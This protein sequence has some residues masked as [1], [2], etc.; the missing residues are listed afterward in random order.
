MPRPRSDIAP[1]IV[2]AARNRFL[3]DGVDG[4]S[5]RQIADDAG[6]SI[7]MVYYYFPTKDDLFFAVV[8]EKYATI[9]QKI[10]AAIETSTHLQDRILH[11][12][13]L[14]GSL[15]D[16]DLDTVRLVVR[17]ALVSS[18]R[19]SRLLDR[20]ER[21]HLAMVGQVLMEGIATGEIRGDLSLPVVFGV[22]V[23]VGVIPQLVRRFAGARL[24]PGAMKEGHQLPEELVSV[25]LTGIGTP[26]IPV[27]ANLPVQG[28]GTPRKVSTKLRRPQK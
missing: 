19:L 21:G 4:A 28:E 23:A 27:A 16:D 2:H 8:E 9:L 5:L 22:T 12:Y 20:F 1:R 14:V 24:P 3:H 26:V 15:S 10:G 25:L 6:T 7:G 17:E 18:N 13:Q 11:L